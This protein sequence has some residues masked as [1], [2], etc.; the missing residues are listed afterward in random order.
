[1][2]KKTLFGISCAVFA[3]VGC[4]DYPGKQAST[5]GND[6]HEA[7]NFGS[8]TDISTN[9]ELPND[10]NNSAD[11]GIGGPVARQSGN[12]RSQP[13][14]GQSSDLELQKQVKVA[15]TT[16]STGTT[17][18]IAEDQ[19]TEIDVQV[20][21]GVVTLNGPVSSEDEKE[22]IGRQVA[23]FKGVKSVRNNLTVGGRTVE[24]RP[25]QPFVPR[26]AGNE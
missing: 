6:S 12:Y 20:R 18:A 26:G 15:L 17:G 10:T 11:N 16:G 13:L 14:P 2:N 23:G 3:L 25:L 21:D 22:S 1:M 5:A 24:A 7:P 19:L 8:S 9:G 4:G